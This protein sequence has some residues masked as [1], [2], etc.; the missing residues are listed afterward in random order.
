[1]KI[2][3]MLGFYELPRMGIPSIP[4]K[5]FNTDMELDETL[6]WTVRTAVLKGNDL[7]L[8]RKVGVSAKEAYEFACDAQHR[9]G[10]N[11]LVVIYPYFVAE[12]SG[13]LE[14]KDSGIVIEAVYKDLW[15]LVTNNDLEVTYIMNSKYSIVEGNEDFFNDDELFELK[16]QADRIR[17][18]YRDVLSEGKNLLLEWSF[19]YNATKDGSKLGD[20]YLI[21]YE[22]R[23][24]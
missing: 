13:T 8:P 24:I 2:N 6:L 1:M 3:K 11:G 9:L 7:N 14:V 20:K 19:A 22:L 15:N 17:G 5:K 23:T 21:F 4:W 16:Y 12:K 10:D 18:F